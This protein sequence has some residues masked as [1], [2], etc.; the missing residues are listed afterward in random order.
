MCMSLECVT[1]LGHLPA[2]LPN[3]WGF[4]RHR[5]LDP[6]IAI[7]GDRYRYLSQRGAFAFAPWRGLLRGT[8]DEK[9]GIGTRFE[10]HQDHV[11]W[12]V[13]AP[14]PPP[15]VELLRRHGARHV[16][17][18]R[19]WEVPDPAEGSAKLLCDGRL[20]SGGARKRTA[21]ERTWTRKPADGWKRALL[22][23]T[24]LD[25]AMDASNGRDVCCVSNGWMDGKRSKP[26]RRVP[27]DG[28]SGCP[29]CSCPCR[30]KHTTSSRLPML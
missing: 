3:R 8:P 13:G 4:V 16:P 12:F 24:A 9:G 5:D 10:S 7:F 19:V 29:V 23:E 30:S 27:G 28:I 15:N 11:E 6:F 25:V 18:A 14:F 1:S 17:Q 21:C 26:K 2:P 20:R 22:D